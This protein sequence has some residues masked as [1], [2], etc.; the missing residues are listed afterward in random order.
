MKKEKVCRPEARV[1]TT[2][3]DSPKCYYSVNQR[4]LVFNTDTSNTAACSSYSNC[5]CQ[6]LDGQDLEGKTASKSKDWK[7][8]ASIR[9]RL[10]A[11]MDEIRRDPVKRASLVKMAQHHLQEAATAHHKRVAWNQGRA[12]IR[13][14]VVKK[15]RIDWT[16][17]QS[18]RREE[19]GNVD[20]ARAKK[21]WVLIK[22]ASVVSKIPQ[23]VTDVKEE[24]YQRLQR[25]QRRRQRMRRRTQGLGIFHF[26]IDV[27][28]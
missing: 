8:P 1:I 28:Q 3:T 27:F 4:R 6:K 16:E 11:H 15:A 22:T 18:L 25:A 21:W 20:I 14:D 19:E 12:Q 26:F 23:I 2:N 13:S 7:R 24:R 9:A 5:I 17:R 10:N